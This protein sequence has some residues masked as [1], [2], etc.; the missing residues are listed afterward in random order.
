MSGAAV[1]SRVMG[2]ILATLA[3]DNIVN[4]LRELATTF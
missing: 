4:A 3:V 2:I 1:I